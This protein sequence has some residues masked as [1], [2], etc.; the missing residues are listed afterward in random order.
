MLA[1]LLEE[2]S[3]IWIRREGKFGWL[4]RVGCTKKSTAHRL[5]FRRKLNECPFART[6]S[7]TSSL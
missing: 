6:A 4:A 5:F 3:E 7:G 2:K 1:I